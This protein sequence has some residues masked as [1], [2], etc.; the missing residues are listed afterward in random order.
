MQF[1]LEIKQDEKWLIFIIGIESYFFIWF[2]LFIYVQKNPKYKKKW[3]NI[4][5]S[6]Y[7]YYIFLKLFIMD[8]DGKNFFINFLLISNFGK[9]NDIHFSY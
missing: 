5:P 9:T 6:Y 1:K 4:I 7:K 2:I 3:K 8:F